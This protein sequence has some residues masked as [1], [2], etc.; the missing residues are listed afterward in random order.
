MRTVV[1]QLA[2][3][4]HGVAGV[5]FGVL[6]LGLALHTAKLVA[7]AR[8]WHWIVR[9]A[10]P[11]SA[12]AY[13]TT[14]GAFVGSIG[15]NAVLPARVGEAF[16][17]GVVR[18]RVPGS[19]VVT[20]AATVILETAV[21]AAFGIGI[22]ATVL[23]AG[24]SLGAPGSPVV[25]SIGLGRVGLGVVAAT[26]LGT[27]VFAFVFRSAARRVWAR[28]AAGFSIV[29]SPRA[30]VTRVLSWKLVAWVLRLAS[31]YAFLVAFH[32]P[33]AIWAVLLVVAAQNVAGAIP[34][35]PG[36]AGTQQAA[37]AI[38]LAGSASG[39]ALLGFGVGMQAATA[40]TDLALGAGA[41]A[42]V[43]ARGEFRDALAAVSVTR[44]SR[45]A[46]ARP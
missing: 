42:A 17:I 37:I 44:S 10:H 13:R 27:L 7:E 15:A 29:R 33:A 3:A 2:G 36:N 41:V 25:P 18:R 30:F 28:M 31:V 8:S 4:W 38:A 5:S 46:A 14:L 35:L 34:I 32:V 21:E 43:A 20:V 39:A 11:T 6:A 9:Y 26:T 24:R 16:R 40:V 1:A 45:P 19:S 12:V 22:V 23:L